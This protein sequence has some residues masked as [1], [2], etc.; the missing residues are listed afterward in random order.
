MSTISQSHPS[1]SKI[2][3][4]NTPQSQ[5]SKPKIKVGVLGATGTVGQ[6]F[7]VLLSTH[8][9]FVI[10]ALGASARSA[11]KPYKDA[12]KWKQVT[13]IP[14][15]AAN[16]TVEECLP[17]HFKDCQIVFSGLDADVAGDIGSWILAAHD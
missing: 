11:G 2:I 14:S 8:P 16:I 12:V 9:W 15:V 3:A 13:P 10:D 1:P 5:D 7:I 6:R 4:P 17:E